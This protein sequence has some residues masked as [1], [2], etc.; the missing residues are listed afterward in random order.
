MLLTLCAPKKLASLIVRVPNCAVA[1]ALVVLL[2]CNVDLRSVKKIA[3]EGGGAEFYFF[4]SIF[5][6]SF[7]VRAFM[8]G[9]QRGNGGEKRVNVPWR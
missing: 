3:G 5:L 1:A 6:S 7:Y 9:R 4:F 8:W 2:R